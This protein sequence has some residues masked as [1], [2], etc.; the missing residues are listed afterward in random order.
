MFLLNTNIKIQ[1]K[2]LPRYIQNNVN[3]CTY[4]VLDVCVP[5]EDACLSITSSEII[6][7]FRGFLFPLPF[8][9]SE[10]PSV[11]IIATGRAAKADL[12]GCRRRA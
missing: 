6:N 11:A 4:L 2:A 8:A 1:T 3:D 10:P 12:N 5:F 9:K 7:N